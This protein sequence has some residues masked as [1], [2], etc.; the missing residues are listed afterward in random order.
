MNRLRFVPLALVLLAT[1]VPALAQDSAAP[2]AERTAAAK[3]LFDQAQALMEQEKYPEACS[4]FLASNLQVAR[5]GTLLNL[6]DCYEKNGQNAS[7]WATYNDALNLGRRQGRPEY[8]AFAKKK[9]AELEPQLYH[10]TITV[11]A[12]AAVEGMVIKRDKNAL[13]AGGWGVPIPIDPGLH[14]I[15]ISAPKKKPQTLTVEVDAAH[16]NASLE[17]PKLEDAPVEV[18]KVET[19]YVTVAQSSWWTGQRTAGLVVGTAG[20]ATLLGGAVTGGVAASSWSK[21]KDACGQPLPG[22]CNPGSDA[23]GLSSQAQT[24][25]TTSTVLF[26]A[27][28]ALAALGTALFLTGAPKE[29]PAG[30]EARLHVA[31]AAAPGYAGVGVS[32]SW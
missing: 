4:K 25:A 6:G 31:P 30:A 16:K 5:V 17:V 14:S 19:K 8:E 11:P 15:E 32:G 9:V 24:L 27:G 10:L 29:L 23:P 13:D 28:G 1:S 21:A 7:A 22:P 12:P 3:T 20:V 26:I 18:A 2:N